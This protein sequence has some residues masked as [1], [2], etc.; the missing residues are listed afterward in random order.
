MASFGGVSAGRRAEER[1]AG[2]TNQR[3]V[4]SLG[5]DVQVAVAV[6]VR[7]CMWVESCGLKERWIEGQPGVHSYH[8]GVE[9]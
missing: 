5:K 7:Q 2:G 3:H 6:Q 8:S 4:S 1:K 9:L